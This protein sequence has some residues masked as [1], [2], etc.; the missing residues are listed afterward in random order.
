MLVLN[1]DDAKLLNP[2]R[3][4]QYALV[5]ILVVAFVLGIQYARE[6][7]SDSSISQ[8]FLKTR[9][10]MLGSIPVFSGWLL[11]NW[12][13]TDIYWGERSLSGISNIF[14]PDRQGRG[15]EWEPGRIETTSGIYSPNVY[16][17]FRQILED[18]TYPGTLIAFFFIGMVVGIAYI[19]VRRG[20]TVWLPILALFYAITLSSFLSNW[21][22]Y[23]SLA[24]A[25]I[26]FFV[27]ILIS[28]NF[29]IVADGTT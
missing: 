27:V 1:K 17:A 23:S 19:C 6:R 20:Q 7:H 11:D 3:A 28:R 24:L 26:L 5:S 25:W 16:T 15:L 4:S 2:K 10:I 29:L 21:L 14:F 13:E 9:V 22:A 8:L 18:F 12:D